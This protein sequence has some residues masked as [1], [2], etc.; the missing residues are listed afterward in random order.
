M[1]ADKFKTRQPG[2]YVFLSLISILV[3]LVGAK[4]ESR[5]Y[6]G[7]SALLYSLII[8]FT[9]NSESVYYIA[10]L[11]LFVLQG[12]QI[13]ILVN[14]FEVLYKPS[15]LPWL[16]YIA[17]MASVPGMLMFSPALLANSFLLIMFDRLFRIYK[18]DYAQGYHFEAAAMLS[19]AVCTYLPSAGFILLFITA[20]LIL[21]P[22]DWRNWVSA[23]LGFLAP[24]YLLTFFLFLAGKTELL[25]SIKNR[26]GL[27]WSFQL[28]NLLPAGVTVTA[29]FILLLAVLSILMLRENFYKNTSRTRSYQQVIIIYTFLALLILLFTPEIPVFKFILPALPLAI[30]T[31]YYL[32]ALRKS[33]IADTILIMLIILILF[34]HLNLPFIP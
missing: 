18:C 31:G 17:M 15:Y 20:M 10:G 28:G 24:L 9:N 25:F 14:R 34:N 2:F 21:H 4:E 33:W 27:S 29:V 12:I 3:F 1:I 7:E 11:I 23:F 13:H 26:S 16:V 8:S 6:A 19:L 5:V 32:L 22:F 30:I